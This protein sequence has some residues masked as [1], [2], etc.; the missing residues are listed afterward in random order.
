MERISEHQQENFQEQMTQHSNFEESIRDPTKSRELSYISGL[1]EFLKEEFY[2]RIGFYT[3]NDKELLNFWKNYVSEQ[4]RDQRMLAIRKR[5]ENPSY[6]DF[7]DFDMDYNIGLGLGQNDT[8]DSYMQKEE[9]MGF[10]SSKS[11]KE[12]RYGP[13]YPAPNRSHKP[14]QYR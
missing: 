2:N 3:E 7:S 8:L 1:T 14:P 13:F 5:K 4:Y 10:R 12:P 9:R 6:N 11:P